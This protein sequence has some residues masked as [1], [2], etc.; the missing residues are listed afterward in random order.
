[1]N[2]LVLGRGG[3]GKTSW[4]RRLCTGEFS[5][6]AKR[7]QVEGSDFTMSCTVHTNE[8]PFEMTFVEKLVVD[9]AELAN[10]DA[11]IRFLE[12]GE[13]SNG[14]SALHDN[15][16]YVLSKWDLRPYTP[17]QY[18]EGDGMELFMP[19]TEYGYTQAIDVSA[20]H[21]HNV[22]LPVLRVLRNFHGEDL[23]LVPAP[24]ERPALAYAQ[25]G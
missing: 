2:I 13:D 15:V 20:K 11:I 10:Y 1:M 18:R 9:D 23:K 5:T 7:S 6:V 21:Y 8:G 24:P 3:T 16:V 12:I 4:I 22:G 14:L 25:S 19:C 17:R